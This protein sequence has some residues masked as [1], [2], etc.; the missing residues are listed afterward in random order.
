[1]SNWNGDSWAAL[2]GQGHNLGQPGL[3]PTGALVAH[4]MDDSPLAERMRKAQENARAT[5]ER[6]R[7]QTLNVFRGNTGSSDTAS[8]GATMTPVNRDSQ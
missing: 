2:E 7:Q 1:M 3:A 8:G 5:A 4:E 6:M